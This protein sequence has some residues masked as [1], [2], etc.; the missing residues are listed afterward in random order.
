MTVV[1]SMR[2]RGYTLIEL[3][4]VLAVLG[5]LAAMA[6]PLAQVAVERSRERE[7]KR[8]L[9]EIRDAIDAYHQARVAGTIAADSGADA[10]AAAYPPTLASLTLAHAD[11]RAE[12]HGESLRFLRNIPRDP[13][14]DSATAPDQTWALRSFLSEA[15]QPVAGADVYDVHSR[16]TASALDGSALS[17]W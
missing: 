2:P 4:A 3:L 9:W 14:A 17:T 12:H 7:L 15:S 11:L 16:S 8:A 6:M 1:S 5:V 10:S 13:F